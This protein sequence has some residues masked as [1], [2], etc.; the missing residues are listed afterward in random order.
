M[1]DPKSGQPQAPENQNDEDAIA[2]AQGIFELAR[3]GGK[4]MLEPLLEAG[5]PVD[6]RTSD[7]ESLLFLAS[8]E[9]HTEVVQ[10][11]LIRGADPELADHQHRTPLMVAAMH[12]HGDVVDRL[13]GA[14]ADAS[15]RDGQGQTALMLAEAAG[16]DRARQALTIA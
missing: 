12:D 15:A 4:P 13:L 9:G 3:K 16:A 1:T 11:L 14:G 2:F 6:L 5:V 8:A 10:M 7:G